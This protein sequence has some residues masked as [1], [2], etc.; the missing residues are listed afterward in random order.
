[1]GD[2]SSAEPDQ[3]ENFQRVVGPLC[4]DVL[5]RIGALEDELTAL[6]ATGS[7]GLPQWSGLPH[8][9]RLNAAALRRLGD[10]VGAVGDAFRKADLGLIPPMPRSGDRDLGLLIDLMELVHSSLAGGDTRWLALSIGE[11]FGRARSP[12][13]VA[14]LAT[15]FS[16]LALRLF[17]FEHPELV[18]SHDGWPPEA[19]FVANRRLIEREMQASSGDRRRALEKFVANDP[20]TGLPR[21]FL[22]FD[23][24]GEGKV[25]EVFGSLSDADFVGLYVP[26]MGSSLDKFD[27]QIASKARRL[28]EAAGQQHGNKSVALIAW[29][30][31]D[32]PDDAP[33]IQVL[34]DKQA[35]KGGKDLFRAVEG[36]SL[37]PGQQV[38][39]IAHS[40]GTVV[41]GVAL[42]AGIQAQR[43]LVMGSP[44][45]LINNP[46]EL[47]R[48]DNIEL[49]T[50]E[51]PGD[52]VT[53]LERFGQDPNEADSGFTR[54]ETGKERGHSSYLSAGSV[55]LVN[56]AA[57]LTGQTGSATER[58]NSPLEKLI[59]VLPGQRRRSGWIGE[60]ERVEATA[61]P[62][63]DP[64]ATLERLADN[65][66][67][68][69]DLSGVAAHSVGDV[70]AQPGTP[71]VGF[72][73]PM[74]PVAIPVA[75]RQQR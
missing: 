33:S 47:D 3:L 55:S 54:L 44:G 63:A 40:Y 52:L 4:D 29:L 71:P 73:S 20:A 6:A 59:P 42:K 45:M 60:L 41:L 70:L 56:A 8:S 12:E 16:P 11:L 46:T 17:A 67:L 5:R 23:P 72:D 28:F 48:G 49:F 39:L 43:V 24:S 21:Q 7:E 53:D 57:V 26:G 66:D 15:A 18:G 64:A 62:L 22:L 25:A 30:G 74:P 13:F 61:N 1:M 50:M 14:L 75:P 69:A 10:W 36:L 2:K 65:A 34:S 58:P 38:I 35:R 19:R 51:A 31:Y 27:I 68:V 9:A 32:A 37:K